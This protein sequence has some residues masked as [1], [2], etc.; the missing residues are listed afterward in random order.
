MFSTHQRKGPGEMSI[1]FVNRKRAIERIQT[2]A[3]ISSAK[4][5]AINKF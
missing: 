1:H 4:K 2:T 3:R 5:F